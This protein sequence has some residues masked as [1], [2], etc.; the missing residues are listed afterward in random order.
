MHIDSVLVGRAG[1]QL[2]QE[3]R[4]QA[5]RIADR[6]ACSGISAMQS[7]P[8]LRARET[9]VIIAG[10]T[11]IPVEIAAALDE[12]DVGAW[13]GLSFS[14]LRN[15]PLW[16]LWNRNRGSVRPPRGESMP[17]LQARIVRHLTEIA[18]ADPGGRIAVVSHAEPIRA[19]VLYVLNLPL[20]E[21]WRID[22]APASVTTLLIEGDRAELL[23][24]NEAVAA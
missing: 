5:R 13:T 23:A 16:Q 14:A 7:S 18:A 12:L 24:L 21:F 2:N 15:D 6:L 10:R 19:A 8:Q 1:A 17:G 22:I 11:G 9:A 20:E 3:G 4:H